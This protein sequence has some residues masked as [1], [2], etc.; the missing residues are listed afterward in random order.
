MIAILVVS[1]L[2]SMA[3]A[4]PFDFHGYLRSGTGSNL[5]GGKQ[6][7]F[8]NSGSQGNE[9]RLGNECGIYGETTFAFHFS[10]TPDEP[11]KFHFV[12]N[13]AY[14]YDNKKDWETTANNWVLR[15]SFIESDALE[16]VPVS[17][18]VGKR[19]YRW[20]SIHMLDFYPVNFAGPG[21]GIEGKTSSGLAW[22]VGIIQNA[23]SKEIKGAG[24]AVTTQVGDAARTSF[25]LR[26]EDIFLT[27]KQNLGFWIAG[28]TTPPTKSILS[29]GHDYKAGTGSAVAVKYWYSVDNGGNE[30]GLAYGNGILSNLGADGELVRDCSDN[31][32]ESC[33]VQSSRRLRFWNVF[34][35]D[36][37][38]WSAQIA[39]AYDFYDKGTLA[40]SKVTWTSLGVHPIYNVSEHF[41]ITSAIGYSNVEDQ[42]DGLG[43]RT[44]MRL[45][46]G[47]QVSF[48]SG[49]YARPVLRAY[50]TRNIWNKANVGNF[51]STS[52]GAS[53]SG[54][55]IG[56]QG[57][58]WF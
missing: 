21:G 8:Q 48:K 9:F 56:I 49:Y 34:T 15:E 43:K 55:A 39:V 7:C 51:S 5:Q 38:K 46:V 16:D 40:N 31:A 12:S 58:I 36:W 50:Y 45:T 29:P 24:S 57:E 35:K 41:Q 3:L 6:E 19:F 33:T 47:P 2:S 13:F 37:V 18:W 27:D 32:D 20:G 30:V 42:S 28:A 1:V 54:H 14:S 23:E 4:G 25:H 44:L 53:Q 26:I 22:K 11:P 52:S 10:E 17:I